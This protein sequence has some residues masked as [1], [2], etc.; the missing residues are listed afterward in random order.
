MVLSQVSGAVISMMRQAFIYC[1]N[2][3]SGLTSDWLIGEGALNDIYTVILSPISSTMRNTLALHMINLQAGDQ[4]IGEG[5]VN[6]TYTI[7]LS[8]FPLPCLVSRT[9]RSC[10]NYGYVTAHTRSG[11]L[12][13][14]YVYTYIILASCTA[15]VPC[16][17]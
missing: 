6:D 11:T 14:Q 3:L 8:M 5:A 13:C 10:K 4:L 7:T 16:L 9:D 15:T 17:G 1:Y 12:T 2:S